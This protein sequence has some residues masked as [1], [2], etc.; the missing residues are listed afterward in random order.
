MPVEA[1]AVVYAVDV[2]RLT[3]FYAQVAQLPVLLVEP[4]YALL[5]SR[6]FELVIHAIP[7]QVAAQ[8]EIT[9]PPQRREDTPIKLGFLVASLAEARVRAAALG[10]QLDPVEREWAF[11]GSRLCDGHDP[12]GNVIQLREP[13][14]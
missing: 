4:D 9:V 13:A 6:T 12:E 1:S 14:A 7:A 3:A 10:G 2:S 5:A 11:R 8:I